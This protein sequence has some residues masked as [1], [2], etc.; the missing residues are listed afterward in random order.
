MSKDIAWESHSVGRGQR[1]MG[2]VGVEG[3]CQGKEKIQV[4]RILCLD[5]FLLTEAFRD[6][7]QQA[8]SP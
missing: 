1:E 4:P 7:P 2:P 8:A 6:N 5:S 3:C